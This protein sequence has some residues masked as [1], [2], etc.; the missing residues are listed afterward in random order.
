[1]V[2]MG[3]FYHPG[4]AGWPSE[5]ARP[6]PGHTRGQL[7]VGFVIVCLGGARSGLKPQVADLWG[8][9]NSP[10]QEDAAEGPAS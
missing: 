3:V 4:S 1:M 5:S 6:V 9:G 10:E 7:L 2:L 8:E